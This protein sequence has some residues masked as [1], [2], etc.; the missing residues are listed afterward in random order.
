M[1]KINQEKLIR[2]ALGSPIPSQ[3]WDDVKEVF[4]VPGGEDID[5]TKKKLI[6]DAVGA[7]IPQ[8]W[9]GEKFVPQTTS[10]GSGEQGPPGPKGNPGDSAY[11]VAVKNG[12]VGTEQEWLNSLKGD[13][14]YPA[15]VAAGFKGTEDDW[16][17]VVANA[18]INGG[19]SGGASGVP[20]GPAMKTEKVT[21]EPRQVIT[22]HGIVLE[23]K[24]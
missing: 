4:I 19:G 18:V 16:N 3:G 14:S 20:L 5:F 7:V 11:Q 24:L 8:Y 22:S 21:N 13:N 6:R 2:D 23:D 10:G 15:A 12:F 1:T 9:D 17:K